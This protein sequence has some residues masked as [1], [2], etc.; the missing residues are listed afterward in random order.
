MAF[1]FLINKHL[2]SFHVLLANFN[3]DTPLSIEE[4]RALVGLTL[5]I[6]DDGSASLFHHVIKIG[7]VKGAQFAVTTAVDGHPHSRFVAAGLDPQREVKSLSILF[8][9]EGKVGEIGLCLLGEGSDSKNSPP[10]ILRDLHVLQVAHLLV[11]PLYYL[12]DLDPP[13]AGDAALAGEIER[14][15]LHSHLYGVVVVVDGGNW[16]LMTLLLMLLKEKSRGG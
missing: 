1:A 9:N 2:L 15:S 4:G 3:E 16:P 12:C 5:R 13:L 7:V 14:E 10:E 8:C 11:E 6:L